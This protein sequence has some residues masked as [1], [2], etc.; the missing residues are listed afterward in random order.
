VLRAASHGIKLSA[1]EQHAWAVSL[2]I[3]LSQGKAHYRM[4]ATRLEK[5]TRPQKKAPAKSVQPPKTELFPQS[6]KPT[7]ALSDEDFLELSCIGETPR[8]ESLCC[9][10]VAQNGNEWLGQFVR[11]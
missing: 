7:K 5:P 4:P 11:E 2:S 6:D 9:L 1:R 3:A 10:G 8:Q